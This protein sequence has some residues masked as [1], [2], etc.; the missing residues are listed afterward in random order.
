[1]TSYFFPSLGL[2]ARAGYSFLK[3]IIFLEFIN[4]KIKMGKLKTIFFNKKDTR[5]SEGS[6]AHSGKTFFDHE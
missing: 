2:P 5:N 4:C 1:M 6:I 3:V